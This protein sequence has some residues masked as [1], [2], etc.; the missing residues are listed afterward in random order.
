[1]STADDTGKP[2]LVRIAEHL[3]RHG[4]EFLVIG[5]QAAALFGS[6][7]PTYDVDL[8]YRRDP[9][10]L[11]RL[12]EALRR[13]NPT[14]RGAPA[15][16]PFRLDAKS[17]A[18]GSNFTFDTDLGPLDLLGWVEPLGAYEDIAPRAARVRLDSTE[19]LVAC[20]DDLIRIKRH[21]GRPKDKLDLLQLE[22]IKRLQGESP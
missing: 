6:A 17:L 22:A 10:N 9:G 3:K 21:I 4:V 11:E 8:C 12:A 15:D 2:A 7:H 19:V 18:L 16:L 5:G 14:L 1:M 20:L 13:L